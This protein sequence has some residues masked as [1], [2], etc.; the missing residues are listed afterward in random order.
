MD[1]CSCW[2]QWK[3][4]LPT[5]GC[6]NADCV[7]YVCW[8]TR[9]DASRQVIQVFSTQ[10][11]LYDKYGGYTH[12]FRQVCSADVRQTYET[13]EERFDKKFQEESYLIWYEERAKEREKLADDIKA[14][15]CESDFKL[16]E[17]LR[18]SWYSHQKADKELSRIMTAKDMLD[19]F[20]LASDGILEREIKMP[21]PCRSKWVPVV[22]EGHATSVMTWKR[23]VFMQ[24]HIGIFG[25]HRSAEKTLALLRRHCWW[26][27]MKEDVTK[28]VDNCMTCIRF[29]KMP[30]KQPAEIGIIPVDAEC[31]EEIMIDL[32][33]PSQPS[34]KEGCRYTLTYVCCLCHGVLLEKT[35]T[36]NAREVRRMF[37]CCIFRSGK[38]PSMLR[39]DRGPEM[40]H[41]LMEE[42]CNLVGIGRRMGTPW[43]PVEQ[44]LV[45]G[46]HRET[47]KIY[48]MLVHDIM[49]CL[50][51]EV[52]ELLHVVE[53][54][55]YN[56]PG[57]HGYTPRDIDRRWSLATGLDK[58]LQPFQVQEF[59][60]VLQ[61]VQQLFRAYREIRIQILTHLQ[62]QTYKRTELANRFRRSKSIRVGDSVV[63]RDQRQRKAGG[64]TPYRQLYTEPRE[65]S[66][67]HGNKCTLRKADGNL[68]RNVHVEDMLL[69]PSHAKSLDTKADI[70]F[71]ED[72]QELVVDDVCTRRSPGD[73]LADDGRLRQ[74]DF[75]KPSVKLDRVVAGSTVAYATGKK[76]YG[77]GR[78]LNVSKVENKITL[79]VYGPVSDGRLRVQ[80]RPLYVENG[81]E[82][83]VGTDAV[84]ATVEA[85]QII[86]LAPLHDGIVQH[87]VARR[88]DLG[89]YRIG[90]A[91][92]EPDLNGDIARHGQNVEHNRAGSLAG[93][94]PSCFTSDSSRGFSDRCPP[95][96]QE[97]IAAV[98]D[99]MGTMNR[100]H[101]Y[102]QF[103]EINSTIEFSLVGAMEHLGVQDGRAITVGA[104]G[105]SYC[106]S[107]IRDKWKPRLVHVHGH[108]GV[109]LDGSLVAAIGRYQVETGSLF[110]VSLQFSDSII[111]TEIFQK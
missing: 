60:P 102:V 15:E 3:K 1:S 69:V 86:A 108:S 94:G 99:E 48:G 101:D 8:G 56:T 4:G 72:D 38:I 11:M 83:F 10:W 55:I 74:D 6:I 26:A 32:E 59:E 109:G 100:V 49:K 14:D 40:K 66:E 63:L 89:G 31:W 84:T 45:E 18:I 75:H 53:F 57:A 33:G 27:R 87:A 39:S 71:P 50:P 17:A 36:C 46:L 85:S 97:A 82:S 5:P 52:G 70:H 91:V 21:P 81:E 78:A 76:T 13:K 65:V 107:S 24:L 37:A 42:F 61:Y 43:R 35:M 88:L 73:M 67:I 23:W 96:V 19:G 9:R 2:A 47:Q 110:C 105:E 25:G 54:I 95:V 7:Y 34:D 104:G 64:R 79:H 22:P 68:L 93:F 44:G 29:R 103:V 98:V 28:W 90:D 106:L 30:Q 16:G 12:H 58:E 77:I 62:D 80:W 41:A 20:R 51:N 92:A 111:L